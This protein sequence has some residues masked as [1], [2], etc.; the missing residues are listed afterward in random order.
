MILVLCWKRRHHLLQGLKFS[1]KG[2]ESLMN[3]KGFPGNLQGSPYSL[4]LGISISKVSLFAL[5]SPLGVTILTLLT[6]SLFLRNLFLSVDLFLHISLLPPHYTSSFSFFLFRV[7]SL[8]GFHFNDPD[9]KRL[10]TPL[11]ESKRYHKVVTHPSP[12]ELQPRP[13]KCSV[14]PS[15]LR[16]V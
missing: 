11:R 14:T 16:R 13:L 9:P 1:H 4:F 5:P 6:R 12:T 10:L 7:F 2:L 8:F 15:R 3:L